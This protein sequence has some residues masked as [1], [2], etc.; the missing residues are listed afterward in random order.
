MVALFA[1]AAPPE[2]QELDVEQAFK[3]GQLPSPS[4]SA[5][6]PPKIVVSP[7]TPK[8]S[9]TTVPE[10]A[11]GQFTRAKVSARSGTSGELVNYR[12]EVEDGLGLS[13]DPF[14][15]AV[16]STLADPRGWI[17]GGDYQFRA[18]GDAPLRV[19]LASPATTDKLCAP[20]Q[21]R[22]EVSC[23]NGDNVVINARR[24]V[25]GVPHIPDLELYRQ[26]VLNHEVGH[27]LGRQHEACPGAG[28]LAP[29]MAQQTL[30]LDGCRANAWPQPQ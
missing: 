5:T 8:P 14:A 20:L 28:Q 26:Y 12:V 29:V 22:G 13:A 25:L 10:R 19:V 11:S 21:T 1:S 15:Q 4:P 7:T 3:A 27:A 17:H 23:R 6:V 9:S 18:T 16:A 30:G 2:V 24:W